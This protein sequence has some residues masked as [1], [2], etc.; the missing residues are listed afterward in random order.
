MGYGSISILD[1]HQSYLIKILRFCGQIMPLLLYLKDLDF[2]SSCSEYLK[3]HNQN[4][5]DKSHEILFLNRLI[6]RF[7]YIKFISLIK[8]LPHINIWS[9]TVLNWGST[10]NLNNIWNWD[11]IGYMIT[12]LM[13]IQNFFI[14]IF[15]AF[16]LFLL[17]E[18]RVSIVIN[19][20]S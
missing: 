3:V 11:H 12:I 8:N 2:Y 10:S 16:K 20:T 19:G 9:T 15:E 6:C 1:D 4:G 18:M 7:Y 13:N 17:K 14:V 5:E